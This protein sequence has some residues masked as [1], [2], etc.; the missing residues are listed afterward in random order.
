M[1]ERFFDLQRFAVIYNGNDIVVKVD[2]GKITLKNAKNKAIEIDG[3][4]A[5]GGSTIKTV[6]NSTSSPVTVNSAVKVIDASKRTKSV[7]ITG[8]ALANTIYSG[9]GNDSLW[10]GKGD[11]TFIFCAG[12]GSD[13][14][15]D[16]QSGDMLKILK[17]DG[18]T[19]GKFTKSK[20]SG[21]TL[22][23]TISG[24]GSVLF[25]NV[26]KSTAFIINNKSYKI[27]GSKLVKK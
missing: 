22:S 10:G 27:S 25:D 8:N 15:F 21:G 13:K 2:S 19:N 18:T 20:F 11:D 16:Y 6:T 24:G 17:S 26:T 9:K 14:I 12:D 23:L 7:K 4:L 3:T 1:S 5:G